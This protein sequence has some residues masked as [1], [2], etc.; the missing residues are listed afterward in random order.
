MVEV[1]GNVPPPNQPSVRLPAA[2]KDLLAK[3]SGPR[4]D[5][6]AVSVANVI[7]S[8]VDLKPGAVPPPNHAAV[9]SE[10]AS[11][12]TVTPPEKEIP[13]VNVIVIV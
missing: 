4:T 1:T 11:A 6:V 7:R 8:T 9:F 5:A 12:V 3:L 10:G 2:A 13:L